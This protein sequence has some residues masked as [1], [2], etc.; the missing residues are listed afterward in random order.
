MATGA[1][2]TVLSIRA[3]DTDGGRVGRKEETR[4]GNEDEVSVAVMLSQGLVCDL[5]L[6][7][8]SLGR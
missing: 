4:E 1:I 8:N 3:L 6:D 2:L 5:V 7:A